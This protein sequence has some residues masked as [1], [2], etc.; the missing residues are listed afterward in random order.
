MVGLA[1][2]LV[3]VPAAQ[4]DNGYELTILNPLAPIVPKQNTPLADRQPLI[5]KLEAGGAEGPVRILLLA[6][7]KMDADEE[8]LWALGMAMKEYFEEEYPGT[9]VELVPTDPP[10]GP[11]SY[12]VRPPAWDWVGQGTVPFLSS[13]W[14]AKTGHG[15]IDGL[16]LSEE[17]F[18]R[19]KHWAENYDYVL[20]GDQT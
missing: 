5:D 18:A 9:E 20:T 1:T 6:Y 17:P 12:G 19:Y 15:Y 7:G 13:P 11:L 16:P 4:A 14:T 2:P 3:P 10:G 8:S